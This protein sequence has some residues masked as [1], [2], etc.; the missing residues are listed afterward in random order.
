MDQDTGAAAPRDFIDVA[1]FTLQ[2]DG[3]NN[4]HVRMHSQIDPAWQSSSSTIANGQSSFAGDYDT[5]IQNLGAIATLGSS[6][7]FS[8]IVSQLQEPKTFFDISEVR[9]LIAVAWLLFT[10]LLICTF[11]LSD[12]IRK[13]P[14]K[15]LGVRRR[16]L[17]AAMFLLLSGAAA[18]LSLTVVAYVEIVGWVG[19]G[20]FT[21]ASLGGEYY[22]LGTALD[23][24]GRT[25]VVRSPL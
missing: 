8:L 14:A 10:V 13:R 22:Y 25:W 19:F 6:I 15:E 3:K 18:C 9:L 16:C 23:I 4:F 12:F 21:L 7:T 2:H 11:P 1:T 5:F 24:A 17:F 20:L